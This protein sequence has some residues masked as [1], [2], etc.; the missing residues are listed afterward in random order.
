MLRCQLKTE[1]TENIY[2]MQVILESIL[3]GKKGIQN[4]GTKLG[5]FW[6][7]PLNNERITTTFY[8]SLQSFY[9]QGKYRFISVV[10]FIDS[11]EVG[12]K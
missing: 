5:L 12:Q 4:L 6:L 11:F 3:W 2:Q 9:T 1:F 10:V 8:F 7:K